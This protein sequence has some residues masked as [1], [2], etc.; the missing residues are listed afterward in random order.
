MAAVPGGV[1]KA[2]AAHAGLV[3]EYSRAAAQC[4]PHRAFLTSL[5]K[6]FAA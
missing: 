6:D 5:Q 1:A 4:A 2:R 3:A